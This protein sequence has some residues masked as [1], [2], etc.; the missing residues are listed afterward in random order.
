MDSRTS[1]DWGFG[2][3]GVSLAVAVLTVAA[4]DSQDIRKTM[5][6]AAGAGALIGGFIYLVGR[7][8]KS[9]DHF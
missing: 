7:I 5:L 8:G 1:R 4:P 6:S 3:L 2:L 9:S